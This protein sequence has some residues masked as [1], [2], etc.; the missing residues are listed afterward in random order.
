MEFL[1]EITQALSY[2]LTNN[3]IGILLGMFIIDYFATQKDGVK[4][5]AAKI[6]VPLGL[7]LAVISFIRLVSDFLAWAIG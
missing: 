2:N 3:I 5:P 7:V 1:Q 6:M 4:Q